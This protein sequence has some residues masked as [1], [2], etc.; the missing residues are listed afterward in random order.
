[1]KKMSEIKKEKLLLEIFADPV[2]HDWLSEIFT[3]KD[4]R[5]SIYGL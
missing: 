5:R 3:T 4:G 1:M 2:V